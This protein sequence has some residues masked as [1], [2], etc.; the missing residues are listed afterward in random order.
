MN[1]VTKWRCELQSYSS[2]PSGSQVSGGVV[3]ITDLLTWSP[4]DQCV[5]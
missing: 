4:T 3:G 5:C 2:I 1:E